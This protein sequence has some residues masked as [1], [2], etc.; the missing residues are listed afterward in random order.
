MSPTKAFFVG[1]SYPLAKH[2]TIKVFRECHLADHDPDHQDERGGEDDP[3]SMIE[4]TRIM[5]DYGYA[6][7]DFTWFSKFACHAGAIG[8]CEVAFALKSGV[9]RNVLSRSPSRSV[10]KLAA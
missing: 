7:Y 3:C 9:L 1:V 5:S 2:S 10:Q 8:F 6:P 4:L